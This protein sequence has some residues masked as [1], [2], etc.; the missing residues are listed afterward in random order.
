V[1]EAQDLVN[2]IHDEVIYI[3]KL[4]WYLRLGDE[5][6]TG[7][8]RESVKRIKERKNRKWRTI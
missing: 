2:S 7:R 8:L 6:P 3:Q 5:K 4:R 1:Q